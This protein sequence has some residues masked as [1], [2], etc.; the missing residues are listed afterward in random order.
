MISHKH[1]CIFIEVPKT[2]SSSV[3]AV[4]GFPPIPHLNIW[5]IAFNMK[6]YW[7]H[8]GSVANQVL[9]SL[10]ML[11]PE[12][13]R[14]AIGE[15]QWN[16]YFKFGFVRN[17]WDR[18]VSLYL[19]KEGMRM[20]KKMTFEEFVE[21]IKY[22]SS[23]CLYPVPHTNQ[24]DWFVDPHGRVLADFIGKFEQLE[25]DWAFVAKKLNLPEVLPHRNKT[26][27][28]DKHYTEYY[29]KQTEETIRSKFRVDIEHFEYSFGA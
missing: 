9:A 6:H 17:P 14:V 12:G 3:R 29:S 23:T 24:L 10:Y 20:S 21:W 13:R 5:Q 27:R 19:R 11:L 28:K 8:Y 25:S 16:T 7:T 18:V 22:S 2:G 15:R 1:K 4:I 26:P